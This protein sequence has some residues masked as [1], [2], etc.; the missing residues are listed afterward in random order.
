MAI[1][2][3]EVTVEATSANIIPVDY[4]ENTMEVGIYVAPTGAGAGIIHYTMD[5]LLSPGVTPVWIAVTAL[6]SVVSAGPLQATLVT[7]MTAIRVS[8][9]GATGTVHA[10]VIQMGGSGS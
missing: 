6:S 3:T 4:R 5:K 1:R 8:N 10:K 7:P 2:P 9:A